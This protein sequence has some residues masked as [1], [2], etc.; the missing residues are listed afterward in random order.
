MRTALII[1]IAWPTAAVLV[2]L[3][4]GRAI[5]LA[6]RNRPDASPDEYH[7]TPSDDYNQAVDRVLGIVNG[8]GHIDELQLR[9]MQA[10][11]S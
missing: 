8:W 1:A 5:A 9:R 3:G 6:D 2:A 4:V 7:Y 11:R 10:D